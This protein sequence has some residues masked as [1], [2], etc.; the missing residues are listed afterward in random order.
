M[1]HQHKWIFVFLAVVAVSCKNNSS[2]EASQNEKSNGSQIP[3]DS[4]SSFLASDGEI[5]EKTSSSP[6]NDLDK[7]IFNMSRAELQRVPPSILLVKI[8][9]LRIR[10]QNE[11]K[12][13][14]SIKKFNLL[15]CE[16]LKAMNQ[17][18][19][20]NLPI[21]ADLGLDPLNCSGDSDEKEN[22]NKVEI[23]VQLRG[24]GS[25]SYILVANSAYVSDEF[26]AAS[27]APIFFK[28][29]DSKL[30]MPPKFRDLTTLNLIA[31]RPGSL[32]VGQGKLHYYRSTIP[33]I[34]S[35]SLTISVNGKKLMN[36]FK[37]VMPSSGKDEGYYRIAPVEILALGQSESC[38]LSMQELK[39]LQESTY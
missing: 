20:A 12:E 33:P 22:D 26:S 14:D 34:S 6:F 16:R 10:N 29:K 21:M 38:S 7:D 39:K 2:S 4:G 3:A 36:E 30:V 31:I 23:R 8:K 9:E 15:M 1:N 27:S 13:L 17:E 11:Q 19:V 18:C 35:L 24:G 32:E 37:L 5:P 25:H 28:R